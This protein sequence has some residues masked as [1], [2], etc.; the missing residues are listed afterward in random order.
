MQF[1]YSKWNKVQNQ[2]LRYMCFS[3]LCMVIL[4]SLLNL[5]YYFP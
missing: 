4:F 2:N 5:V 1:F 3:L